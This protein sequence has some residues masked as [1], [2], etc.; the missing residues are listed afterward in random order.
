MTQKR[1]L[2]KRDRKSLEQ[3]IRRNIKQRKENVKDMN[4]LKLFYI[5]RKAKA[6]P[7]EDD[8]PLPK[9]SG[10]RGLFT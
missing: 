3:E 8:E 7:W 2:P 9:A 4:R 1:E 5:L 6:L 10:F